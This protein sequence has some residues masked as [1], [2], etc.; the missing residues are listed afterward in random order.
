MIWLLPLGSNGNTE[1]RKARSGWP[2][3][4][5]DG[6]NSCSL[7]GLPRGLQSVEQ[8]V[9][10]GEPENYRREQTD[11]RHARQQRQQHAEQVQRAAPL[12]EEPRPLRRVCMVGT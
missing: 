2:M 8:V 10:E 6:S 5:S 12:A 9:N 4:C 3:V 7:I 1:S 11:D